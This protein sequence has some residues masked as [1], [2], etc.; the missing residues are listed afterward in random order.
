MPPLIGQSLGRYR[1]LEQL[2]EGGMAT[3]YRGYDTRLERD[4]A[5]KVIRVDQFSP[6]SLERVLARFEREAKSLA[7]LSHPNIVKVHD[8]GEHEGSPYL[9]LEYVPGRTLK[10]KVGTPMPW[11]QAI[12]LLLPVAQALAYAHEHGIIHRDVKPSNILLTEKGQPMLSDFGVAK[13]LEGEETTFL[14]GTGMGIGTPEYMAPEQWTGQTV[15][16]SDIYALGVV[17]YE[18]VTGRKPYTADTPAAILLKQATEPL[19]RP[20]GLVPDLPDAVEKVLLKAL[21]KHP[22]DRYESMDLLASTVAGLFSDRGTP[23]RPVRVAPSD[24]DTDLTIGQMAAKPAPE[25]AQ[26]NQ[27]PFPVGSTQMGGQRKVSPR[28]LWPL[29]GLAGLLVLAGLVYQG[30]LDRTTTTES[31]TAVTPLIGRTPSPLPTTTVHTTTATNPPEFIDSQGMPMRVVPAGN[32]LMGAPPE[33]HEAKGDEGPQRSINLDAFAIDQTEVSVAMYLRCVAAGICKLNTPSSGTVPSDYYSDPVYADYPVVDVT[34]LDASRYCEWIDKR[35]PTEAEWEKAARGAEG[36]IFPWGNE[37]DPNSLNFCDANCLG[38]YRDPTFDDGY[39][40]RSPAGNYPAGASPYGLLDMAG[41]VWE[42][43]A[44]WYS[45][46]YYRDPATENPPGPASGSERV[47][48]GGGYDSRG[49]NV[50]ASKRLH[51][52]P[53]FY[54]GSLGFRCASKAPAQSTASNP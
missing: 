30:S 24:L 9:V 3:V 52:L 20:K 49:T 39:A 16:A 36:L 53:A 54:S 23:P 12:H 50:R 18:L 15:P 25:P 31:P 28:L 2:G 48:R 45:E 7:R 21:A 43:V 33:D 35:L 10:E 1:I 17:V 14:T 44:D 19:P 41:N 13:I 8:F 34:W 29:V 46:S 6:A 42:W 5:I 37:W 27:V 26:K 47:V 11:Q 40:D 4:V 38:D 32:F 22:E 51:H